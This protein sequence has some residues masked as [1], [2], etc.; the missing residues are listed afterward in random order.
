MAMSACLGRPMKAGS[1][2]YDGWAC[3]K[4][5]QHQ[6]EEVAPVR[7]AT[8]SVSSPGLLGLC[9]KFDKSE[10]CQNHLVMGDSCR[11]RLLCEEGTHFHMCLHS[12]CIDISKMKQDLCITEDALRQTSV[13]DFRMSWLQNEPA[14][15][16]RGRC[17]QA[18]KLGERRLSPNL[19]N[20]GL[21]CLWVLP[22]DE[23][24][25][26]RVWWW[27]EVHFSSPPSICSRP[28]QNPTVMLP[29]EL[30]G[31][32]QATWRH[33][34]VTGQYCRTSCQHQDHVAG[35]KL[36]KATRVPGGD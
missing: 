19:D 5:K 13:P 25:V 31:D 7:R 14:I 9:G 10:L 34:E 35:E 8:A 11:C 3:C 30:Q 4:T 17:V 16:G 36:M 28:F 18:E 12:C 2:Q 6:V 21:G 32:K 15:H 29:S 24:T 27:G 20:A 33:I 22:A 26:C 1:S 23:H